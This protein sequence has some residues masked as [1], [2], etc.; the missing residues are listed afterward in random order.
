MH[1]SKKGEQMYFGMKAHIKR[2]SP[3][4]TQATKALRNAQLVVHL[5]P[6]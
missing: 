5:H 1:S 6:F 4:A 2:A 3:L